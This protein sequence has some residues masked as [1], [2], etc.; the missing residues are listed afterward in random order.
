MK[1]KIGRD[2]FE[3][4][5]YLTTANVEPAVLFL[6]GEYWGFYCIQQNFNDDFIEKNYLIPKQNVALAKGDEIE[7]GPEEKIQ[8]FLNFCQE[9][10]KKDLGEEKLYEEIKNYI[11]V[12]SM[13]QF[14]VTGLYIEDTDWPGNDDGV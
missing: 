9:Y 12:E 13:I 8:N 2:L 7:E 11:D 4:M 3:S 14:F 10:S 5:K 1:D 6:N